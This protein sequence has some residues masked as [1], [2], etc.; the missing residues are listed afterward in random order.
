[1]NKKYSLNNNSCT[2]PLIKYSVLEK[3][4]NSK[5]LIVYNYTQET[6]F[7]NT[8]IADT[9]AKKYKVQEL[10]TDIEKTYEAINNKLQIKINIPKNDVQVLL[11]QNLNIC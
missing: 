4:Q 1:M 10:Y 3:D 11:L 6:L 8:S 5:V 7:G 9:T 2:N